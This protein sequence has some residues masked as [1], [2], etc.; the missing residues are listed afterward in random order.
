MVQ[1]WLDRSKVTRNV[2]DG[3]RKWR[4]RIRKADYDQLIVD[5]VRQDVDEGATSKEIQQKLQCQDVNISRRTV[6]NRP[7]KAGLNYLKT[8]SE[9]LLS[10]R[11]RHYRLKWAK[12]MKSFDW[13]KVIIRDEIAIRFDAVKNISRNDLVNGRWFGRRSIH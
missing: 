10:D 13:N 12:S 6:R 2:S 5:L 4:S 8:L 7:V 1:L 3:G 11:Q 9:S